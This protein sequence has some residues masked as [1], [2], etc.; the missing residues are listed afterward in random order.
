MLELANV[1]RDDVVCDLGS[2]DGRIVIAAAKR[3]GCRSI[4]YDISEELID[5]SRRAAEA[6]G[7]EQLAVFEHLDMFK[8]DLTDVTVVTLYLLP[9]QNK[10][11]LPQ[12]E[13]LS[14]G[15]RIVAYQNPIPG[16]R[17]DR[18][19]RVEVSEDSNDHALYLWTTPL[20]KHN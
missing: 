5:V 15:I 18:V 10:R 20:T 19:V 6:S 3:F 12:L 17:P 4:G 14:P 11:L 7:V 13:K 1:K 2:G 16:I 8:A 9:Q